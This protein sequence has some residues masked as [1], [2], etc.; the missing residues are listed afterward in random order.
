MSS[1]PFPSLSHMHWL[2]FLSLVVW[3]FTAV[4]HL[5]S[6]AGNRNRSC[7]C[8]TP[9]LWDCSLPGALCLP[10]KDSWL[11]LWLWASYVAPKVDIIFSGLSGI[12]FH[13]DV[14]SFRSFFFHCNELLENHFTLETRLFQ[15][16][17]I[18][19]NDFFDYF[20]SYMFFAPSE[21]QIW[22]LTH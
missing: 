6:G 2:V 22:D 21:A 18:F 17:E 13:S 5:P 20:C 10:K 15:T 9:S 16:R 12:K 4:R 3:G 11:M 19:L 8:T 7:H 1:S 14:L